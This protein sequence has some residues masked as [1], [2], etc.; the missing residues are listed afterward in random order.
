MKITPLKIG[1]V[2]I[3]SPVMLAPMAGVTD[4][5]FR[6]MIR[7]Y[8][9]GLLYAEMMASGVTINDKIKKRRRDYVDFSTEYPLSVQI[10]GHDPNTIAEAA[11]IIESKGAA[12]ID[13]NFGCPAKKLVNSY[14]GAFLMR[15][16]SIAREILEKAV[17]AVSIP[18]TVKMRLGW[19]R[20]NLNAL[21]I[22]RIAE[23][24]GIKMITIHGRTR[25]QFFSETADW[26]AIAEIKEQIKIPL[27]ANGDITSPKT[28]EK[29]LVQSK[30]D[31]IMIGRGIYGKPWLLQQII[32]YFNTGVLL[33]H[34]STIQI[35]DDALEHYKLIME[36][37]GEFIGI[38]MARKHMCWYLENIN[39]S[40]NI[41]YNIKRCTNPS[42]V[43]KMLEDFKISL[44]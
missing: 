4:L 31:G 2:E 13:I 28:A 34:P 44:S 42:E 25:Q 10:I 18:V 8:G 14:C 23:D 30:A 17:K 36:H 43:I 27:I 37:Y 35:I 16:E 26:Q 40:D 22:C 3:K 38:G 12:I 24:V 33:P 1:N 21:N 5:P 41:I 15:D 29:A 32:E 9:A 6:H 11:K 39:N 20:E 19:D 7:K